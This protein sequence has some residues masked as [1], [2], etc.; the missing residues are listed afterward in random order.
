MHQMGIVVGIAKLRENEE[1]ERDV[2]T[3]E[4]AAVDSL[5]WSGPPVIPSL[6][7]SPGPSAGSSFACGSEEW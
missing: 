1:R 7:A 5:S 3:F 6:L 4:L 2:V